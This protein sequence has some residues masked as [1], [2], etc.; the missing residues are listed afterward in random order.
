[1]KKITWIIILC[2]ICVKSSYNFKYCNGV[3]DRIEKNSAVILLENK[4][5]QVNFLITDLPKESKEGMY[6]YLD[7]MD[8]SFIP[9]RTC[10][11]KTNFEK[12]RSERL[13]EILYKRMEY[14]RN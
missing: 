13:L 4:N 9:I 11:H 1:M 14:R 8:G 12:K 6:I 5:I 10:N 3:I 2:F 7:K